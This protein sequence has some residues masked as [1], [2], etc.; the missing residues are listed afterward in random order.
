[1]LSHLIIQLESIDG[2]EKVRRHLSIRGGAHVTSVSHSPES[3]YSHLALQTLLYLSYKAVLTRIWA[4]RTSRTRGYFTA[5]DTVL[6]LASS[7]SRTYK[8][9]SL[10]ALVGRPLCPLHHSHY[11]QQRKLCSC[12]QAYLVLRSR[13]FTLSLLCGRT[14]PEPTYHKRCLG[15]SR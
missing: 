4:S 5:F 15:G 14:S 6:N 11:P 8:R 12:R 13:S 3:V 7:L 1:M 9:S 10:D 2:P